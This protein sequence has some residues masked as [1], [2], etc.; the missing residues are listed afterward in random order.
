LT[1]ND[2]SY[3]IGDNL[4]LILKLLSFKISDM[5]SHFTKYRQDFLEKEVYTYLPDIRKLGIVDITEDEFYKLIGL[6][7]QEINQIKNPSSNEVVEEDKVENEVIEI[8]VKPKVKKARIVKPKK[9]LLI[10]EE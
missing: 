10:V 4:E 9:K 7:R 3:I 8:E 5:I 1:G 2:K 6:T